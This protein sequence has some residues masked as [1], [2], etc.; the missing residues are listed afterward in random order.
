MEN[1]WD[2]EVQWTDQDE[3]E[4]APDADVPDESAAY[5]EFLN[6]EASRMTMVAY[7]ITNR[8]PGSEIRI[9]C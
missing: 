4:G 8:W 2:G 5:L 6:Q 1:D 9:I 3:V 7:C